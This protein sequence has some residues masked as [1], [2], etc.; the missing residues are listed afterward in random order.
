[1]PFGLVWQGARYEGLITVFVEYL[2]AFGAAVL[3]ERG[4]VVVDSPSA[5]RALTYMRDSIHADR[6]VPPAVLTWQE[7][8]SRFAFQN[9]QALFMRNWPYASALL[10]DS[11]E[12]RVAGRVAV[13]AM[14]AADG[15][16]A[17]A[18]LGGS[19]LAINAYSDQ[20]DDAA[21]LIAFL[22]APEQMIDRTER[23]GQ[24]P[25]RRS[26]YDDPRIGAALSIP[27]ADARAVIDHAAARPATPVYSQLSEILQLAVHRAL[28]RQ[29]EPATAL[30]DAANEMRGVLARAHLTAVEP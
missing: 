28:T 17:A 14:P 24:F 8:Q 21:Q 30:H 4:Q 25:P 7:E 16:T 11:A 19:L 15:G 23:T 18:T 10:E 5:V 27:P 22:L 6:V 1:M 13:S 20:K 9:G 12:S 26:L 29:Q 2:G 3:D